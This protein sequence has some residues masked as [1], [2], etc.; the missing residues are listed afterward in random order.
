MSTVSPE[1]YVA[2]Q[3]A[4]VTALYGVLES[5]FRCFEKLANL[6]LQAAKATLTEHEAVASE[7][8][9]KQSPQ[10]LFELQTRQAQASVEKVQGYWR[11]VNEIVSETRN[12][13]LA[14]GE[15]HVS[16]YARESQAFFD[17]LVKNAPA[18]SEAF[19]SLWKTGFGA[20][21][22]ASASSF[23]QA[24]SATKQAMEVIDKAGKTVA[25]VKA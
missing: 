5:G 10:A 17:N 7:A 13:L 11:H 18:G 22:D 20:A 8:V 23:E 25:N 24:K 21:R 16:D 15:K 4:G 2:A 12:E 3:K 9:A 1:Q 6:N 19:I 14:A